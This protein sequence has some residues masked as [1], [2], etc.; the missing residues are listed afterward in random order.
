MTLDSGRAAKSK[1]AGVPSVHPSKFRI[2]PIPEKHPRQEPQFSISVL[3]STGIG[4]RFRYRL[5]S[6]LKHLAAAPRKRS[7][8]SASARWTHAIT[9]DGHSATFPSPPHNGNPKIGLLYFKA[10]ICLTPAAIFPIP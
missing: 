4:L 3:V 2:I 8:R 10:L 9:G 6:R 1:P 7:V 5:G